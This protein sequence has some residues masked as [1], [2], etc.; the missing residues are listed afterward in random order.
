MEPLSK[1]LELWFG[2]STLALSARRLWE[3][4]ELVQINP[5]ERL[6]PA[7]ATRPQAFVDVIEVSE[8]AEALTGLTLADLL[9]GTRGNVPELAAQAL[10]RNTETDTTRRWLASLAAHLERVS[11]RK[12][13]RNRPLPFLPVDSASPLGVNGLHCALSDWLERHR[14]ERATPVQWLGR[15]RNLSGKGL[16][17]EE[18]VESGIAHWLE[19]SGPSAITGDTL[20]RTLSYGGLRMSVVPVTHRVPGVG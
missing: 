13:L 15:L 14:G 16:R 7:S 5:F 11:Q 8:T 18:I 9:A 19:R 20:V 12:A 10:L 2:E 4:T 1:S 6:G 17:E 3:H